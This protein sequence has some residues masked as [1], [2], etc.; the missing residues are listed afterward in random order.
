[1]I[2]AH[3]QCNSFTTVIACGTCREYGPQTTTVVKGKSCYGPCCRCDTS[4]PAMV[5]VKSLWLSLIGNTITPYRT[6]NFTLL[7]SSLVYFTF[8]YP[9]ACQEMK[10]C[11]IT[12][13][14]C[15]CSWHCGRFQ[16]FSP[17]VVL[18]VTCEPT[19]HSHT[20]AQQLIGKRKHRQPILPCTYFC[21]SL[22][23]TWINK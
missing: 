8:Q 2:V 7:L 10:L 15:D 6:L 22:H 9:T 14:R 13:R 16:L 1:M 4:A 19:P 5:R 17:I 11:H 12:V 20:L 21:F 23:C 3:V 18:V